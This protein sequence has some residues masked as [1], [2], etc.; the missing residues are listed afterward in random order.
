M[1]QVGN[2]ER[3]GRS[4][5][6]HLFFLGEEMGGTREGREAWFTAARTRRKSPHTKE[7]QRMTQMPERE[8]GG[9]KNRFG[10]LGGILDA[11]DGEEW[12]ASSQ[13]RT[14]EAR[15]AEREG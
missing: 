4:C 3:R 15:G 12:L 2:P 14:G 6:S 8:R 11:V 5:T 13:K 1:L 7:N 10:G 9:G